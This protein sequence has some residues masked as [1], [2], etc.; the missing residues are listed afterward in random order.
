MAMNPNSRVAGKVDEVE[1]AEIDDGQLHQQRR[2]AEHGDV[3]AGDAPDEL[4]LAQ[5]HQ[6]QQQGGDHRQKHGHH[7]QQQGVLKAAQE[8]GG[9]FG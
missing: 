1:Q 2:G 4:I 7:R 8:G 6:S 5:T 3:G 9:V